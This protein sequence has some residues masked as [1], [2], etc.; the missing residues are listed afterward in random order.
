M[1]DERVQD[2]LNRVPTG[3][4]LTAVDPVF[5]AD[6]SPEP[7]ACPSGS[8]PKGKSAASPVSLRLR[9]KPCTWARVIPM[10]RISRPTRYL[11]LRFL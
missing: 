5:R 4:Q 7:L 1:G 6:P 11:F 10:S 9:S 3:A 2:A 8:T